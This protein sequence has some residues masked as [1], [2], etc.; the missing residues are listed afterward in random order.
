MSIDTASPAPAV[1]STDRGLSDHQRKQVARFM[2]VGILVALLVLMSLRNPDLLSLGSL[3]TMVETG[4]PLMVLAAGATMVILLGGI[5]LSIGSLTA[6]ASILTVL[7]APG[8]GGWVVVPVV[9]VC[10]LA[11]LL[12]G[13]VH[14][15][16]KVPSFIVTLG[17]LSLW[18]GLALAISGARTI[19]LTDRE[20]LGWG[21]SQWFGVPSA[22]VIA[23]LV[24]AVL[25]VA[26]QFTPYGRW[27][28]SIGHAEP[29]AKLAGVPVGR[30]KIL[31][32]TISGACAGLASVLLV[33]RTYSG[34][35]DLGSTLLLPAVAAV[36]VGGTAITGG[37]GGLS[38][39]VLGALVVTMLRSGLPL[40]GVDAGYVN[41]FYGALII[42]AVSVT[43]ERSKVSILK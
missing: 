14:V 33:A 2:P 5:D 17:G 1:T 22:L 19:P 35:P 21:F 36:V 40:L 7:W 11:G 37:H 29:A 12:Q 30:V 43:I 4:A 6:L 38:K 26:K 42:L 41:I 28:S 15:A 25:G 27:I 34:A 39:T 10:A 24:V 32:F 8:F 18:G 31:A 3:R 13:V 9:A 20:A 23:L 16:A